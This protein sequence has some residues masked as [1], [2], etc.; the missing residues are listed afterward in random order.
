MGV[1]REQVIGSS[2]QDIGSQD[3]GDADDE[4]D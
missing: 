4:V 3:R 1:V 2:G